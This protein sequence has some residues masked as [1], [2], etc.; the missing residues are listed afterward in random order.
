MKPIDRAQALYIP[1]TAIKVFDME[2]I[3]KKYGLDDPVYIQYWHWM[4]GKEDPDTGKIEGG[5]LHG[6]LGWSQVGR[7]SVA[8]MIARRAPA[9][10]ELILWS[11]VPMIGLSVWFGVKSAENHNKFVDHF[12]RISAIVGWSIPAFVLGFFLLSYFSSDLQWF[13]PGR[14]TIEIK[15]F[16]QSDEFINYT[17]MYTIDALLNWRLD[18]FWDALRHLVLPVVTLS[19]TGWAFLLRVTRFSMLETLGQD[20]ITVARSKGLPEETIIRKHALPNAL[21]PV[22]T[23]GGLILVGLINGVVITEIIFFFPGLGS[24]LAE[25]AIALDLVSVAGVT[26]FSSVILVV[27]NLMVDVLYV[28]VDPRIRL[29]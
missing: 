11:I 8:E 28:V 1:V 29:N 13:P 9:T 27:G 17:N 21:I 10:A 25:A 18:I 14:L 24:F 7:S 20:Y 15:E 16:V 2:D 23:M 19:V 26:L 4:V 12:L 22:I 5:V 6:Y 3:V